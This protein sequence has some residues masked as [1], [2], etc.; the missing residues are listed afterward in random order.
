LWP[1]NNGAFACTTMAG[2]VVSTIF[3]DAHRWQSLRQK[4]V[5]SVVF[6]G[7]S[8]VAGWLLTPLGIS[9]IRATP[10]WCLYCI[11]AAAL[12]FTLLYWVCD[13]NKKTARASFVRPAGTNT[14]LT[15]L[16]PDFYYFLIPLLG[17]TYFETHFNLGGW[18]RYDLS[19]LRRLCW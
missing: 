10:T 11:G 3:S 7:L 12:L 8:L 4:T 16:I 18:E 9:K 6:G 15:Y 14:L 13:V 2:I 5:M 17:I 1:F 19:C